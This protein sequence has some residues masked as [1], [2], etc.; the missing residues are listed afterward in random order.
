M[1]ALAGVSASTVSSV[2]RGRGNVREETRRRVQDAIDELGYRPNL[3]ARR[4]RSGRSHVM[5]L[6]LP[7]VTVP[8]F[9]ECADA[10]LREAQEHGMSVRITQTHGDVRRERGVCDDPYLRHVDGILLVPISLGQEDMRAL[11]V[12]KPLIVAT[13]SST[14]GRVDSF[15]TDLFEAARAVVAH[16]VAGGRRRIA[17]LAPG[18]VLP[19]ERD[20]RYQG[21]V[22]GLRDA[23]LPVSRR[24]VVSTETVTFAA[25]ARAARTLVQRAPETDAVFALGKGRSGWVDYGGCWATS[26]GVLSDACGGTGGNKSITGSTG[27]TAYRLAGDVRI[28]GGAQAGFVVRASDPGKGADALDGYYIGVS[29][30]RIVLGKQNG[31]WREPAQ[32]A[33]PGGLATGTWYHLTVKAV[34]CT[35]TVTGRPSG[36]AATPVGFTYKDPD[37]SFTRGA[38]GVRDQAGTASWRHVTVTR[39]G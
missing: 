10:V 1:A 34:G 35:L 7:S 3:A 15:D 20:E 24:R 31:A 25:G 21:Y 19:A 26:G 33:I 17:A 38:V 5:G 4:L 39:S 36:S 22:A 14:A 18:E 32:T 37:C 27:W 9:R 29:S 8:Y 13:A 28:D 11:T 12:T 16:L 30:R 23:G 6:V 2:V